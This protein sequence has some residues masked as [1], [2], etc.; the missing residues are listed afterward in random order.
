MIL[1]NDLMF[2]LKI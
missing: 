2:A 1:K